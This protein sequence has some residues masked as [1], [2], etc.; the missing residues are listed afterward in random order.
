MNSIFRSLKQFQGR[1][2]VPPDSACS[3]MMLSDAADMQ[4]GSG[5]FSLRLA[6]N[7]MYGYVDVYLKTSGPGLQGKQS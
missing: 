3:T 7:V 1:V 6:P 4:T 5:P 2:A